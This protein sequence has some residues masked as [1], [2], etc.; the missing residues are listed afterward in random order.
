VNVAKGHATPGGGHSAPDA[1][2][3]NVHP[4]CSVHKQKK[5]ACP[6]PA[7]N[8]T[9]THITTTAAIEVQSAFM[10]TSFEQIK[11]VR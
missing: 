6:K 7:G 2:S 11:R 8:E 1:H 4:P 10:V 5:L 9:T 3:S